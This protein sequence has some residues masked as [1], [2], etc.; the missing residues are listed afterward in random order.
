MSQMKQLSLSFVIRKSSAGCIKR[1]TSSF[2]RLTVYIHVLKESEEL[3]NEL[4]MY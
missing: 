4:Q 1:M 2:N 3:I